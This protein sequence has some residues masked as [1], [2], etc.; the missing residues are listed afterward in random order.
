MNSKYSSS[1]SSDIIKLYWVKKN[2][3]KYG[4]CMKKTIN[5]NIFSNKDFDAFVDLISKEETTDDFKNYFI[6]LKRFVR[7]NGLG[8]TNIKINTSFVRT[9]LCAYT[10]LFFPEVM[11]IDESNAVSKLLLE[12]AKNLTLNIKLILL[13]KLEK[14]FSFGSIKAIRNLLT[15]CSEFL[16]IFN[17]WKSLDM[18]AVICNLA[19]I[20]M[21]MERDFKEIEKNTN[22]DDESSVELLRITKKNVESEKE[23]ILQKVKRMNSKHGIEIFNKYY[24]FLNQ[25]FD[26]NVQKTKLAKSI[27]DNIQKAYW[28]VIKSDML[29]IPPDFEK[30]ISL[31]EEAKVILKQCVPN[32]PD[33]IKEIDMFLEVETLRHYIENDIDVNQ[34]ISNMFEFIIKKIKEFQA[35]TEEESFNKFI[36]DFNRLRG[37]ESCRL[38]EILIFFFQGVMP[39]LDFI[40]QSKRSF[41]EWYIKNINK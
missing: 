9:I 23:K 20:Y 37:Q 19:K 27:N 31:L 1:I 38:S 7:I 34:F 8:D 5:S 21:D 4:S 13:I 17:E 6:N 10:I 18:E 33:L 15:K 28:D 41:E 25:E 22:N 12:K 40:L 30:V 24:I 26:L 3:R 11:N 29:K 35:R 16:Q 39:R 32:R 14:K 2:I 36:E